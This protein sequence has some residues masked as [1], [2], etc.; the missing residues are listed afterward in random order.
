MEKIKLALDKPKAREASARVLR[1]L[2]DILHMELS[3]SIARAILSALDEAITTWFTVDTTWRG[4]E[5]KG[6]RID[7]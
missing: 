5:P 1:R 4:A 3:L 6:S 7:S 2:E